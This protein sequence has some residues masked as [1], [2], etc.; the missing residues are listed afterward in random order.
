VPEGLLAAH[1]ISIEDVI[2]LVR[3]GYASATGARV[4]AGDK[5]LEVALVK[6]THTGRETLAADSPHR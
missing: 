4:R 6:I 3:A 2:A 1:G 5:V